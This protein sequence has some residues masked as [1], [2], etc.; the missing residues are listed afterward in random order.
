MGRKTTEVEWSSTLSALVGPS[1]L[2]VDRRPCSP[3]C[4]CSASSC[5]WIPCPLRECV[6]QAL[7]QYLYLVGFHI[8]KWVK[9]GIKL[10]LAKGSTGKSNTPGCTLHILH[11]VSSA[12]F[13]SKEDLSCKT[14]KVK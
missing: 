9:V 3:R 2:N 1:V 10:D 11:K 12:R 6:G 5:W 4:S 13:V 7:L 14:I 8:R